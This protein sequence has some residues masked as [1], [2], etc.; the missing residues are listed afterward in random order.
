MNHR[1]LYKVNSEPPR[2]CQG[3]GHAGLWFD[4]F[5]DQWCV[6]GDNNWTMKSQRDDNNPKLAWIRSVTK[7][8]VGKSE[9]IEEHAMRMMR[10]LRRR[11]GCAQVFTSKSRFVTGLG[12]SHPVENGFAWH[13]TL[14]TPYLPGSSIKGMVLAWARHN[15]GNTD[16][17]R[18]NDPLL[19]RLFG[20]LDK[21]GSVFFLDAVPIKAVK[22]EADVM[23][24]H[25]AGWSEKD[26][27]GD[28]RSPTPVPFLV[29]AEGLSLL[30]GVV[31][32]GPQ[33][34][35]DLTTV[36]GWLGKALAQAGSGAKTSV[37]YGRFG[38]NKERTDKWRERFNDEQEQ[39]EAKNNPEARWRLELKGQSEQCVLESVRKKLEENGLSDPE[40]RK[41]F[42]RAV[43][44]LYPDMVQCWRKRE[45]HNPKTSCGEKKL[46]K[47]AQ[48]IYS[49][50]GI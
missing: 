42:A 49:E 40:E 46:K 31:P 33:G 23:T 7:Q 1:P 18:D 9:H 2:D 4:K 27:P 44:S 3:D 11:G 12:R 30:F 13:P 21:A 35:E 20:S 45:P 6:D 48:L 14:G 29:A 25:Y 41:A 43:W 16:Q 10:L 36:M 5:C 28:W 34:K 8:S 50:I 38:P 19:N 17:D 22:L 47:R 26:P 37:G 24:P 32:R 39:A 15:R